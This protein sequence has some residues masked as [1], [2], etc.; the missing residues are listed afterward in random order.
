MRSPRPSAFRSLQRPHGF[1][2]DGEFKHRLSCST[3]HSLPLSRASARGEGTDTPCAP[4][5]RTALDLYQSLGVGS[6]LYFLPLYFL[7]R[8][9]P[10]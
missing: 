4:S 1:R 7:R 3:F 5:G 2:A 9:T 8:E 6:T 10:P